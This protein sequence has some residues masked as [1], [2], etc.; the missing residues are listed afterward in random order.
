MLLRQ[1]LADVTSQMDDAAWSTFVDDVVGACH[2]IFVSC[3]CWYTLLPHTASRHCWC[4]ALG[5]AAC[6]RKAKHKK[7]RGVIL[8]SGRA[9]A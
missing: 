2:L 6:V 9:R 4:C 5:C 7:A 3:L 1:L 8:T